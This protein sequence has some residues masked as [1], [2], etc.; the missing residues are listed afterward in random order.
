MKSFCCFKFIA[1]HVTH[2]K[3]EDSQ[4]A[5]VMMNYQSC[6]D[7]VMIIMTFL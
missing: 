7:G 3:L 2:K 5:E 1:I 6:W 4:E